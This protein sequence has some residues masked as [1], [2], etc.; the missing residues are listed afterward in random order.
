MRKNYCLLI[1]ILVLVFLWLGLCYPTCI[2][3]EKTTD[4]NGNE[5]TSYY[6][7]LTSTIATNKPYTLD[8]NDSSLNFQYHDFIGK[9]KSVGLQLLN[10]KKEVIVSYRLEKEFGLNFFHIPLIASTTGIVKD[11]LYTVQLQ[12]ESNKIHT[13]LL[14]WATPVLNE[15]TLNVVVNPK[16]LECAYVDGNLVE[17]VADLQGGKAPYTI[18]WY[19]MNDSRTDFLYQPRT[20]KLPKSGKSATIS[21]D[22][23]PDY[24]V[25]VYAMDACG[26]ESKQTV[27]LT[28]E[29]GKKKINS[30]FISPLDQSLLPVK[31]GN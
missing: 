21:V 16:F 29:E 8:L 17:F 28:C 1:H 2:A 18:N 19:V 24:Y 30:L 3:Q 26:N 31:A 4:R 15:F 25:L 6:I 11:E 20:E 10:W 7:D 14:K 27:H 12:D 13:A 9:T 23:S 5:T 22:K